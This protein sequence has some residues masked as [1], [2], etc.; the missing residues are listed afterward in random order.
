MRRNALRLLRPTGSQVAVEPELDTVVWP[1][2]LV[3]APEFVYFT[4]FK[5]DPSLQSQFKKWGY[6]S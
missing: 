2:G 1:N 5:N 3:L 4:A 6:I